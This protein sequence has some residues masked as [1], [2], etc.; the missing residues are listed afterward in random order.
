M[1]FRGYILWVQTSS[2]R[3]FESRAEKPFHA[4]HTP[5]L[6]CF[7]WPSPRRDQ[8]R[9]EDSERRRC[10]GRKP[11]SAS[12]PPQRKPT[13][14]TASEDPSTPRRFLCA[15]TPGY[16]RVEVQQPVA[17]LPNHLYP[18]QVHFSNRL[19]GVSNLLCYSFGVTR[20]RIISYMIF[21]PFFTSKDFTLRMPGG[22][23]AE[24]IPMFE[25]FVVLLL[26]EFYYPFCEVFG[27]LGYQSVPHPVVENQLRS[28][29]A[30]RKYL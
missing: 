2:V 14:K 9:Q 12:H 20:L 11:R 7:L 3:F 25:F 27:Y 8:R 24:L 23:F 5:G 28:G 17:V 19:E 4:S 29:Y 30:F 10:T 18:K 26:E 1:C 15:S 16:A 13:Q 22:R 21:I 6:E